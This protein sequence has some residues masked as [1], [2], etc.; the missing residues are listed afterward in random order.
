VRKLAGG[1]CDVILTSNLLV[2]GLMAAEGITAYRIQ[3]PPLRA[4]SLFFA[5]SRHRAEWVDR[6]AAAFRADIAAGHWRKDMDQ[7]IK[8]K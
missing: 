8:G 5:V 7:A 2:R 1:R 6:L 4:Y 3:E